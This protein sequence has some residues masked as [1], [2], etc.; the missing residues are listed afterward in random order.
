MK[1][2]PLNPLRKRIL[3]LLKPLF[4]PEALVLVSVSALRRIHIAIVSERFKDLELEQRDA[5]VWPTLEQHLSL[6]ELNRIGM[7]M[8]MDA[9]EGA[10]LIPDSEANT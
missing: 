2:M 8:L 9:Q 6:E 10:Q 1:L 3:K 4:E 7:C 5:L